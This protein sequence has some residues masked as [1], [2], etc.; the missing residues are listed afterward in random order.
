MGIQMEWKVE[1]SWSWSWV[2]ESLYFVLVLS[3]SIL[4]YPILAWPDLDCS[5]L[6][7]IYLVL[8]S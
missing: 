3:Y 4:S 6:P 5:V 7:F 8:A 2:Y 1:W